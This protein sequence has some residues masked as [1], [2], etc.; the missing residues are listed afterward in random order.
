[1]Y[2]AF[3]SA[4]NITDLIS[5]SIV[6]LSPDFNFGFKPDIYFSTLPPRMNTQLGEMDTNDLLITSV[7]VNLLDS[8][9]IKV[10]R[11]TQ[12][13]SKEKLINDEFTYSDFNT[14]SVR[15]DGVYQAELIPQEDDDFGKIR[16]EPE[17]GY[18]FRIK[19][20]ATRGERQT[21]R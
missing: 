15:R 13:Q 16:F 9:Q 14:D 18:P 12:R 19:S 10:M 5:N 8:H 2:A 6:L 11:D 1:M 20:I 17:V 4:L 21:R 3:P 7:G